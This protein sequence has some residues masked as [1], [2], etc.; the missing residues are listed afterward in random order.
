MPIASFKKEEAMVKLQIHEALSKA[1]HGAI[2]KTQQNVPSIFHPPLITWVV[3]KTAGTALSMPSCQTTTL[4]IYDIIIHLNSTPTHQA[5]WARKPWTWAGDLDSRVVLTCFVVTRL[6]MRF[7]YWNSSKLLVLSWV[8]FELQVLLKSWSWHWHKI[9]QLKYKIY[10]LV[11][12]W[13]F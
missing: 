2:N 1:E 5:A 10:Y 4:P 9:Y 11:N 12:Q 3:T 6:V 7:V 8:A 13:Q